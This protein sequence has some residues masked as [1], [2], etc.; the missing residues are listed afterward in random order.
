MLDLVIRI[1]VAGGLIVLVYGCRAW[2][3]RLLSRECRRGYAA[4]LCE[5]RIRRQIRIH[6][7][8]RPDEWRLPED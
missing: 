2:A 8:D 1:A 3:I 7:A 6:A 5:E 4:S